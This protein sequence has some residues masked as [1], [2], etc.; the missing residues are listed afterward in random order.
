MSE[1][2][3]DVSYKTIPDDDECIVTAVH[4]SKVLDIPASTIRVWARDL[5]EYLYIKK[6]NGNF[7][8]TQA[9][10]EQFKEIKMY[11]D[12]DYPIELIRDIFKKRG[13]GFGKFDG[14]L[15]NPKDPLGYDVLAEKILSKNEKMMKDF[16]LALTNHLDKREAHLI[17]KVQQEVSITVQEVLESNLPNVSTEVI[18]KITSEIQSNNKNLTDIVSTDIEGYLKNNQAQTIE[19]IQKENE[20]LIEELKQ[21]SNKMDKFIEET[22]ERYKEETKLFNELRNK[23]D[24]RKETYEKKKGLFGFFK[25]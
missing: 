18:N 17:E 20:D 15:V 12:K 1:K 21:Q 9:S 4:I 14:G 8:Y 24:E 3:T 7:K 13:E 5:E 22:S 6:I 16:T 25:K 23:M 2:F 19:S 10:I 11:R